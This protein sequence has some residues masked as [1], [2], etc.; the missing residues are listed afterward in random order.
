MKLAAECRISSSETRARIDSVTR[1]VD[2]LRVSG[3]GSLPKGSG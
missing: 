1:A 3:F 2:T